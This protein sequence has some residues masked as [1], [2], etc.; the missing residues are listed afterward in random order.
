MSRTA[1]LLELLITVRAKGH[2]TVDEM[3]AEFNVSRRTMLRDLHALSEMGVPLA[4]RSG[5]YGGY[6]LVPGARML[7]LTLTLDEAIGVLVS[8]E[9]FGRYADT[10]F[11]AQS[12]SALTKL[13]NAFPA[14]LLGKLDAAFACVA[15]LEPRHNYRAPFLTD[16]L[17]ASIDRAHLQIEYESR[18]RV[19]QRLIYPLGVYASQGF[20][21]VACFDYP[22]GAVLSLRADRVHGLDRV[23]GGDRPTST[24]LRQYLKSM[25]RG[26]A[27]MVPLRLMLTRGAARSFDFQSVFGTD[28]TGENGG[29]FE[30]Q[31]PLSEVEYYASRLLS[32]GNEVTVESPVELVHTLR[33][34]AGEVLALY[35]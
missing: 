2:F 28:A 21:Y 13:R 25:N 24:T 16:L 11:A 1:R 15:V 9:S 27:Q 26:A 3:A 30:T 10:P 22:R 31:I 23:P 4:A 32:L 20:W 18:S 14:D 34:K 12:I 7:P 33:Q 5:P 17:G 8:Y 19:S 29:R 6:S 35:S